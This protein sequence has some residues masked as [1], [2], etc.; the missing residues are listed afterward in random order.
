MEGIIGF[1][2]GII[3]WYDLHLSIALK[4]PSPFAEDSIVLFLFTVN[5]RYEELHECKTKFSS[6]WIEY[7]F[8]RT[9]KLVKTEWKR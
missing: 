3:L 1:A 8:S 2:I 7:V 4:A 6:S 5:D 9:H